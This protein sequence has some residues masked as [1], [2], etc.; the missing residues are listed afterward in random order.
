[1]VMLNFIKELNDFYNLALPSGGFFIYTNADNPN[2]FKSIDIILLT[3]DYCEVV[4]GCLLGLV[5]WLG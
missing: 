3:Q 4:L 1:M 5:K 2:P